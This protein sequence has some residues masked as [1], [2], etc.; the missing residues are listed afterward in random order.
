MPLQLAFIGDVRPHEALAI[1]DPGTGDPAFLFRLASGRVVCYD[2][3]CTHEECPVDFDA[4]SE[5]FVCPCHGAVF[6][7]AHS[8]RVLA[9]PTRRALP[10]IPL[11]ID[12]ATGA[13][14]IAP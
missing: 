5:L 2:G 12:P 14:T 13:I 3:L 1:T 6:D 9:G 11:F 8:G 7:P 4:S 10:E